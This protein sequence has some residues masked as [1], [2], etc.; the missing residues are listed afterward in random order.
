MLIKFFITSGA[1]SSLINLSISLLFAEKVLF[2][3]AKLSLCILSP[4]A[5]NASANI[6]DC[7][8]IFAHPKRNKIRNPSLKIDFIFLIFF[9]YFISPFSHLNVYYLKG[10]LKNIT[11][12]KQILHNL[13]FAFTVFLVLLLFTFLRFIAAASQVRYF[14]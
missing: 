10:V 1:Y 5:C 4:S 3:N 14:I 9:V 12:L 6:T 7:T 11:L 8:G 2:N 13:H